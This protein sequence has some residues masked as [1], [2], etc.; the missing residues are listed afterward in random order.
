MIEMSNSLKKKVNWWV[1]VLIILIVTIGAAWAISARAIILTASSGFTGGSAINFG[2]RVTFY[3]P[4]CQLVLG[5]CPNC[6][7]CSSRYGARCAAMQEV[8]FIPA[9]SDKKINF[10]CPVKGFQ[11][12]PKG[13]TPKKN[14]LILGNGLSQDKPIQIGVSLK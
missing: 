4:N 5:A 11:Y 14:G 12:K 10:V 13:A 9:T 2:G 8:Q 7:M 1:A 3:Q 6:P